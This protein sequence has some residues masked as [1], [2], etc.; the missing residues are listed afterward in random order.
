MSAQVDLQIAVNR[1]EGP[2]NVTCVLRKPY[3]RL[4]ERM[5]SMMSSLDEDD[6]KLE[7]LEEGHNE[8]RGEDVQGAPL[9]VDGA[10]SLRE[11]VKHFAARKHKRLSIVGGLE[12]KQ[13]NQK[14][15]W[16]T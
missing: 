1:G 3:A 15:R 2:R 10:V 9:V 14:A 13:E 12:F 16:E 6:K 8:G 4:M 7:V 5:G 11:V